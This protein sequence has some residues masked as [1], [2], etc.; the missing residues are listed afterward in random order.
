MAELAL[1]HVERDAFARHLDRVRVTDFCPRFRTRAGMHRPA[2]IIRIV[3]PVVGAPVIR[4][5]AYMIHLQCARETPQR[6]ADD[7]LSVVSG[8]GSAP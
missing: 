2:M 1:D 5:R 8:V 6:F 7:T 4:V 3:E